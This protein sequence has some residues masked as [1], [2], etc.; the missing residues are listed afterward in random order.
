MGSP[1][2]ARICVMGSGSVRRAMSVRDPPQVGQTRGKAS[3]HASRGARR[4]RSAAHFEDRD[5][6]GLEAPGGCGS[7]LAGAAD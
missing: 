1:T 5:K 3:D 2:C 7:G 6:P 4:A